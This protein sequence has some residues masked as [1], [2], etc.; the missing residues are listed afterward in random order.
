MICNVKNRSTNI[1][2][3]CGRYLTRIKLRLARVAHE[4]VIFYLIGFLL[5]FLQ[6][7]NECGFFDNI[8]I[9][10]V[11]LVLHCINIFRRSPKAA[12]HR[13]QHARYM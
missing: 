13:K 7:K 2:P 9:V 4:P 12:L 6:R 11:G 1:S 3:T 5:I 8:A 10:V